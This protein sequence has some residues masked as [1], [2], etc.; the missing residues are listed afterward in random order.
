M[1]REFLLSLYV[2][3]V[4]SFVDSLLVSFLMTFFLVV[5]FFIFLFYTS[6][7]FRYVPIFVFLLFTYLI[8]YLLLREGLCWEGGISATCSGR[9]EFNSNS[10]TR[11]S[12][13]GFR[14]FPQFLQNVGIV[15]KIRSMAASINI[16]FDYYHST[17]R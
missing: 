12:T 3:F 11:Y 10:E 6:P 9:P 17:V 7:L 2:F 5:Y 13:R 16:I 4:H 15:P 8:F 1:E 14:D